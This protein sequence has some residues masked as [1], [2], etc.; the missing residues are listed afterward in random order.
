[1]G[2]HPQ[3]YLAAGDLLVSDIAGLGE[4]RQTFTR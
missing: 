3:Q 4:L 1:M 2:M